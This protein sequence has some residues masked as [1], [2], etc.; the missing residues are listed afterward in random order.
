MAVS[1]GEIAT[2]SFV[3]LQSNIFDLVP[4]GDAPGSITINEPVRDADGNAPSVYVAVLWWHTQPH[5][6]NSPH[7]P[8]RPAT[9][10][11]LVDT[12]GKPVVGRQVRAF[13]GTT[14]N[15]FN[16]NTLILMNR[17]R[18]VGHSL[19]RQHSALIAR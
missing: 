13:V 16:K 19:L 11:A 3:L 18:V 4:T 10:R 14:P 2:A 12:T 6:P 15:F 17:V 5:K 7:A 1:A 8:S 9:C